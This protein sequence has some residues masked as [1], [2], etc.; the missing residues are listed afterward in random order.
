M[1][2]TS[3][4]KQVEAFYK[5]ITDREA[6]EAKTGLTSGVAESG[7]DESKIAKTSVALEST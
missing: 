1:P 4:V 5:H 3:D 6:E 2:V 7:A